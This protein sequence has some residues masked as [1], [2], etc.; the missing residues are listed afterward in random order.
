ML[1]AHQFVFEEVFAY[2]YVYVNNK[3]NRFRIKFILGG[4][5]FYD[6]IVG[7]NYD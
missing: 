6:Y 2:S 4:G 7:T 1:Y 3:K 5:Y